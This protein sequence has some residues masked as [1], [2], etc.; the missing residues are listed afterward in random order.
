MKTCLVL[1]LVSFIAQ[2]SNAQVASGQVSSGKTAPVPEKVNRVRES[3]KSQTVE[4]SVSS[5]STPTQFPS[6]TDVS[7]I[8]AESRFEYVACVEYVTEEFD[9][10]GSGW[11]KKQVRTATPSTSQWSLVRKSGGDSQTLYSAYSADSSKPKYVD[12]WSYLQAERSVTRVCDAERKA[13]LA[14]T[15][16]LADTNCAGQTQK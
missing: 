16:R 3:G 6:W 13:A 7:T 11:T 5:C 9:V 2:A 8:T 12:Y 1:A 10:T 4:L 14:Q 15:Y